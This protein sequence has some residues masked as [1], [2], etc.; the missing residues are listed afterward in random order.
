MFLF[1]RTCYAL[2]NRPLNNLAQQI[3]QAGGEP[4]LLSDHPTPGWTPLLNPPTTGR[5]LY[6]W[7]PSPTTN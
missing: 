1:D 6:R 4:F 5:N 7:T 3:R 2:Q